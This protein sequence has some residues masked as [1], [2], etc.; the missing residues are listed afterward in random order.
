MSHDSF[1]LSFSHLPFFVYFA[2]VCFIFFLCFPCSLKLFLQRLPM[3]TWLSNLVKIMWGHDFASLQHLILFTISFLDML[4]LAYLSIFFHGFLCFCNP[5]IWSPL[6]AHCS[7]AY[8]SDVGVSRSFSWSY[9][10]CLHVY[11]WL[12]SQSTYWLSS[13]LDPQPRSFSERPIA[14]LSIKLL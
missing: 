6:G 2:S 7:I 11:L 9:S 13:Q 5:H 12:Q 1:L 14:W 10:W 3:T 4:Y 8:P